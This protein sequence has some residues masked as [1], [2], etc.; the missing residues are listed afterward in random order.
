MAPV[1]VQLLEIVDVENT[2]LESGR[3]SWPAM[4]HFG[5]ESSI[6]AAAIQCNRSGDLPRPFTGGLLLFQR[7]NT[8]L[9]GFGILLERNKSSRERRCPTE[10]C[11]YRSSDRPLMVLQHGVV[12][13]PDRLDILLNLVVIA[14][15]VADI[16]PE[17]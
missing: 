2:G 17:T 13:N 4:S 7:Q 6:Q 12:S 11:G 10:H 16:A 5:D 15:V 14:P 3:C 9:G 1:C 8:L